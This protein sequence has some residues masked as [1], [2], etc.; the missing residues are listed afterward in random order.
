M[1]RPVRSA[2]VL[3][4]ALVTASV[5]MGAAP[6]GARGEA[7]CP[8]AALDAAT[9]PVEIT[10]W[11]VQTAK[12]EDVLNELVTRFEAQQDRVRVNLVNQVG[13]QDLFNKYRA[14]LDTGA[15]P[16][17][18]EMNGADLQALVDSRSVVP[19]EACVTADDYRLSDYVPRAMAAYT[20]K[21]VQWAMPWTVSNR[22]LLYDRNVF[23]AAGL[24]PDDPPT[25]LDEVTD[26]SRRIVESGA[27]R[28]GIAL[29]IDHGLLAHLY[30]KSG[31]LY[32]NHHNGRAARATKTLL[33]NKTGRRI[34]AWWDD[35]V[36]S[37]LAINTGQ[38]AGA[39]PDH[40]LAVGNGDAAMTIDSSNVVGPVFDVLS[41]GEFPHVEPGIA[42]LP[43]L[44]PGGGVM[45]GGGSLWLPRASP[46]EKQAA[47]W[48]FVKFLS[49]PEQQAALTVGARGGYLPIRRSTSQD[50]ALQRMW[51][52]DPQTRVP[53][54]QLLSGPTDPVTAGPMLGDPSGVG[55]AVIDAL[56]RMLA[57]DRSPNDA[58]RQ[59]Q[60]DADA[61]L[62]EYNERV[63]T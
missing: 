53:Y 3:A 24:D 19:I 47:A 6:A 56:T 20:L 26:D 31:Q 27:A 62:A 18:A 45:V 38:G 8:V 50:P 42:P 58:L 41:S 16:D 21:G 61:A 37:G 10:F 52:Q 46:P 22:V 51:Q 32:A 17:V 63:G 60:H 13:Y 55:D 9:R 23:R 59:A 35:I 5:G 33:D 25:T 34:W 4:V 12:N 1:L 44:E 28:H 36:D 40:L 39:T 2:A 48:E 49:A 57:G 7:K 43:A 14:G 54:D 30:T 15:L 11:H 29:R